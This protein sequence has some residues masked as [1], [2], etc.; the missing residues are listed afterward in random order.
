MNKAVVTGGSGFI[1]SHLA[2]ALAAKRYRVTIIDD[3]STGKLENI[4]AL[5]K[6]PDVEFVRGSI[7]DL[8]LLQE[9]FKEAKYVFHLAA[10]PSV[11]RS[12]ENPLG[13]HHPNLT[14]TLN[15]LLAARD[16]RVK[17][18]I[19]AS[20]S[21]LY[22]GTPVLPKREDMLPSPLSPYAV[23]KLGGEHYCEVFS[24]AYGLPTAC[25]RYFNV[26]GPRQDPDSQYAAVI[27]SFIK[28]S[29]EGKP[30]VIYGD[31]EQSRD[32]TFV[33][34]AVAANILAAESDARGVYNISRGEAITINRLARLITEM[35]A[36]QKI[37][38]VYREPRPGDVRHSLADISRAKTFGYDPKYDL[39]AGVAETIKWFDTK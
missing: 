26:Y 21:S 22:G 31:G 39:K 16:N 12:I 33:Y 13:S 24:K 37:E 14:G 7:M 32:F 3:L 15:V 1:G 28:M 23:T 20:S 10:V 35:A 2:D 25:L 17:K 34:D 18:V 9:A 38:P 19:Y 27:P 36:K 6:R 30:P 4:G 29:R 5:L 8:P 11:A